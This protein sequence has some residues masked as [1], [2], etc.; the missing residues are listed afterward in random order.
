M[1]RRIGVVVLIV[2]AIAVVFRF[3]SSVMASAS[4]PSFGGMFSGDGEQSYAEFVQEGR[5]LGKA[6]R[7]RFWAAYEAFDLHSESDNIHR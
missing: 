2:L 3:G 1:R 7:E 5:R 6:A 4:L